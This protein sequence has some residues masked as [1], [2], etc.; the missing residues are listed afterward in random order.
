[1]TLKNIPTPLKA[2]FTCLLATIGIGYLFAVSYLYLIE[3]EPHTGKGEGLVAA[4]AGKYYGKREGTR[5]GAALKGAMGDNITLVE[6]E[7]VFKWIEAGSQESDFSGVQT[8][9]ENGCVMCHSLESGMPIPPLGSYEE[10]S[11]Y[12]EVDMGQSVKSLV[13]VSHVHL[14]GMSFIFFL[15]GGIFALST[16]SVRWRVILISTPF[17]SVW[18]DIGSWWFT[19]LE[20]VFAYTV[21]IGGAFMGLALLFQILISLWEMWF[22]SNIKGPMPRNSV[23]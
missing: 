17:V 22:S 6:K 13:R 19:K 18:V 9:F 12:T 10:V 2:L 15:T 7:A 11:V 4:V 21:I 1:M 14:F 23:A 16:I 5:L 3:I 8:I 20:P